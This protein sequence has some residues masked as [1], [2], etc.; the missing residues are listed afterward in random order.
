MS[1]GRRKEEEVGEERRWEM[2]DGGGEKDGS[3]S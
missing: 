3:R 1:V 2:G